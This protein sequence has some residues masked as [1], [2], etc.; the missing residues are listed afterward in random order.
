MSVDV[1]TYNAQE[2]MLAGGEQ[3]K[4]QSTHPHGLCQVHLD[5]CTLT[6]IDSQQVA[7]SLC[8]L[9]SSHSDRLLIATRGTPVV[10]PGFHLIPLLAFTAAC[11]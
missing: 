6:Q 9:V 5:M 10:S 8:L 11:G 1:R 2:L 3:L 4:S 7:S